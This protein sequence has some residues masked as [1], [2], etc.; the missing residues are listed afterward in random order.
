MQ[1]SVANCIDAEGEAVRWDGLTGLS[2]I[3]IRSEALR[4]LTASTLP[5]PMLG[6]SL[7]PEEPI[8]E[9]RMGEG[10][11]KA[12]RESDLTRAISAAEKAGL[13]SYRVEAGPDGTI[14]IIVGEQG[15]AAPNANG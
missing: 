3:E 9:R 4:Q 13:K 7:T 14:T 5:H 2:G 12:W 6:L 1:K 11:R 10:R 8:M 15:T